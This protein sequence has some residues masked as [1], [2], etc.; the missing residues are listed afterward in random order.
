MLGPRGEQRRLFLYGSTR[1]I[2]A[3]P[4][5][6]PPATFTHESPRRR[7]ASLGGCPHHRSCGDHRGHHHGL[8][9]CRHG[10][11]R[12]RAAAHNSVIPTAVLRQARAP[13]RRPP[14]S[15]AGRQAWLAPAEPLVADEG[16]RRRR[17]A[18]RSRRPGPRASLRPYLGRQPYPAAGRCAAKRRI[19]HEVEADGKTR[20]RGLRPARS[21]AA[22]DELAKSRSRLTRH[23]HPQVKIRVHWV[24]IAPSA[25]CT[26]P[27]SMTTRG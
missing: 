15:A 24:V 12:L 1:P 7:L 16:G 3:A 19:G 22:D 21:D 26:R 10:R 13:T 23:V 5:S 2:P 17:W 20:T 18:W 9:R 27:D 11:R 6:A 14:W 25:H 8:R 4:P